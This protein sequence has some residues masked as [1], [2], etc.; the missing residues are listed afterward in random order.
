MQTIPYTE[1]PIQDD[2]VP[3][4]ASGQG[5]APERLPMRK[6]VPNFP[7]CDPPMKDMSKT[8]GGKITDA[9]IYKGLGF[10]GNSTLSVGVTYWV[11]PTKG[12]KWAREKSLIGAQRL[13]KDFLPQ[14]AINNA[15]DIGFMLI[16]GTILTAVMAP[17]VNRREKIAYWINQKAGKDADVLPDKDRTYAKPATL[18]D[19]IEQELNKRVNYN[20]TSKDL[21]KARWSGIWLPVFG[22]MALGKWS[23]NRE[24]AGKWSVDTVSWKVG[25][26]LY[27]DVLPKEK[28][29]TLG[30]FFKRHGAGIE[31]V[32]AN[33]RQIYDRL[34]KVELE[35]E[36]HNTLVKGRKAAD[37]PTSDDRMMIADQTR[38]LG[39][40]VGWTIIL[41][42]F[43]E[44]LTFKF[45]ARRVRREEIKA[46]AK[47]REE[48]I[49]PTGVHVDTDRLGHVKLSTN[50]AYVPYNVPVA[51]SSG[52][53][54]A[55]DTVS[56]TKRWADDKVKSVVNKAIEQSTSHLSAAEKS[57]EGTGVAQL[58]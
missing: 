35:H 38:L 57:R 5:G 7:V 34:Q 47:M 43:V 51:D 17:L 23:A 56:A 19:K 41:A 52:D 39:K 37:T 11:N 48:G 44:K 8:F 25:Q 18:E 1:K 21:W 42:E 14:P 10:V 2:D 58:Q 55:Q 50:K 26:R 36:K 6:E 9:V 20:Q 54:L 3:A 31:D 27:D 22:D 24:A 32:K 4:T 33:N 16:A 49:I 29:N 28:V 30:N 13:L 12:A 45:Q 46:I 15:V 40:E 53:V